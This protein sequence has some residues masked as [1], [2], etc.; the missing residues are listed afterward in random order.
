MG[1]ISNNAFSRRRFFFVILLLL[2]SFN[3]YSQKIDS[4]LKAFQNSLTSIIT[5]SSL[6]YGA[7]CKS[8]VFILKIILDDS[9]KIKN[10][11]LSDSLDSLYKRNFMNSLNKIDTLALESYA[12]T[13]NYPSNTYLTYFSYAI[14]GDDCPVS[15][16]D[17]LKLNLLNQFDGLDF[18]GA[19]IWLPSIKIKAKKSY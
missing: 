7:D 19:C 10:I 2:F 5:S 1:V 18:T 14:K 9:K 12:K 15:T 13:K 6:N 8:K 3:V 17:S 4:N 11:T 16:F